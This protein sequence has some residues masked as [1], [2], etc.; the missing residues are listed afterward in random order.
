VGRLRASCDSPARTTDPRGTIWCTPVEVAMALTSGGTPGAT[1]LVTGAAG[2]VGR[3]LVTALAADGYA[4]VGSSRRPKPSAMAVESWIQGDLL[5]TGFAAELLRDA[6]PSHIFHLAGGLGP[7]A[8]DRRS[9]VELHVLGTAAL[10]DA[11]ISAD[12]HPWVCIASSSAVYGEAASQPIPEW[13]PTRP[14]SD[15]AVSKAAMEL[16]VSQFRLAAGLQC[17]VVRP[18][19]LIGPGL[20]DRLFLSALARQVAAQEPQ[21]SGVVYVGNLE[22]RRDFLDVRDAVRALTALA[23]VRCMEPVV[24][25]GSGASWTIGHCLDLLLAATDVPLRVVVDPHR[26]RSQEIAEQRADISLLSS[27]TGW[28]PTIELS[29]SIRDVLDH[30]RSRLAQGVRA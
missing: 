9:L 15:Y 1:A 7:A 17:C 13:A 20:T 14:L 8:A 24:N 12:P 22:P 16:V 29:T 10:L 27:L 11:V 23:D 5:D 28:T 4:V 18:F 30:W 26:V 25:I 19:N 21:G 3:H 6:R 2:F